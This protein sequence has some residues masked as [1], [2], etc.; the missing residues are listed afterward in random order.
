MATR[1]SEGLKKIFTVSK[2]PFLHV[3]SVTQ[4][5]HKNVVCLNES[6]NVFRRNCSD[7][8]M[9][10][11]F[12]HTGMQEPLFNYRVHN[13]SDGDG[14]PFPITK[15]VKTSKSIKE[16]TKTKGLTLYQY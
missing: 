8:T 9:C 2:H 11:Q 14:Q 3:S 6:S 4:F 10:A 13:M 15:E 7:G 16:Y 12:I 1:I 5:T